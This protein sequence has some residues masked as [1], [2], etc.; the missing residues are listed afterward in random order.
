MTDLITPYPLEGDAIYCVEEEDDFGSEALVCPFLEEDCCT[1][2][3]KIGAKNGS[4]D[5]ILLLEEVPS[6]CPIADEELDFWLAPLDLIEGCITTEVDPDEETRLLPV[7]TEDDR[8]Y[9]F[10]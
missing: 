3:Q 10:D 4:Q 5:L 1:L 2:F 8:S 9:A 7:I 6:S